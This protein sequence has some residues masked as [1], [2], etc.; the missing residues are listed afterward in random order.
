MVTEGCFLFIS[1][2]ILFCS[3]RKSLTDAKIRLNWTT[4]KTA[5]IPNR[6]VMLNAET[7]PKIIPEIISEAVFQSIYGF[8]DIAEYE[9]VNSG[10][11]GG[12]EGSESYEE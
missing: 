4:S 5:A 3:Q 1:A 11:W 7:F 9:N 6:I 8:N 2:V 10:S 12:R